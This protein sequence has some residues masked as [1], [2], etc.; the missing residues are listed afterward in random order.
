MK[1]L[2]LLT[3]LLLTL[4]ATGALGGDS[5]YVD[6]SASQS[7]GATVYKTIGPDGEVVFTDKP[8]LGSNS[9]RVDLGPI[10]VQPITLPKPLP[11]R[12]LSPKDQRERDDRYVGPINF[13]IVSPESGATI[14]PGQRL[15]VLQVAIDPLPPQGHRFYAIVDGQP[16]QGGS[17]GNSLDISALERGSHSVQAV[18]T[19]PAGNLLARSQTITVYVKRPGDQV[20][21]YGTPQATQAPKTPASPGL[22]APQQR[23]N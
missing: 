10:N 9:E 7:S 12:K 2:P 15:V 14:P 22:V 5:G 18:L 21:E 17:S 11:T 6:D 23:R 4:L 3:A 1:K 16:W 20:P 19:D 8:Q 13:A